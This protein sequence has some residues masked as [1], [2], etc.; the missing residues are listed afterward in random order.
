MRS[1]RA[2]PLALA[3]LAAFTPV[4]ARAQS[5]RV[6]VED[7]ETGAPVVGAT[8][9]LLAGGRAVTAAETGADGRA[10]L[11][12]E[13]AGAF[14]L[15]VRALGYRDFT[16]DEL[17]VS[18]RSYV[19]VRVVLGIDALP[20]E[21]VTVV[22][23]GA[24]LS[25]HMAGF[26]R[27]RADPSLGGSFLTRKDIERRPIAVPTEL[28]QSMP[29]VDIAPIM[30]ADAPIVSGRNLVW[31]PNDR[32]TA[33]GRRGACLAELYVD[34]VRTRQSAAASAD[35]LLAGAEI[36]GVEVYPRA[37]NAPLEYQGTG[38]C[39]VVLFWTEEPEGSSG[40]WS[41]KR[42][43]VGGGLLAVLVGLA[44]VN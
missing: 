24:L 30:T 16:S 25:P 21:P 22:A 8:V 5:V 43:A 36:A 1:P 32:G 40:I 34:G 28:L 19:E 44:V 3:L 13:E 20:L 37:S 11:T 38:T 9:T 26:E 33:S 29:S 18:D 10:D 7:A 14:S 39:G 23:T 31:F 2:L 4:A 15:A 12:A 17:A 35:D 6:A 42:M 41:W 27:R